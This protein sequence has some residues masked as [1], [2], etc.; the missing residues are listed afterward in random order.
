M[1]SSVSLTF[2]G[3]A[4]TVT[5][6]R[7]VLKSNASTVM[8]D[9][10]LFQ[11]LKEL[12]LKNWDPFPIKPRSIDAIVLTHA[13]LDHCGY[14]PALVRDGFAGKIFAT[15]W[16][17]KLAEVILRDSARLQLEDAEYATKKGY[18]KHSNPRPIYTDADVEETLKLF[19]VVDYRTPI[20]VTPD[21]TAIFYPS[22]H[23]LGSAF[24]ELQMSGK[25]VVFTGD[26]GRPSHPLLREPDRIP[27]GQ[28]DAIIT[29]S[30]YGDRS[31]EIASSV[32]ED[33]INRTIKRGGS[34]LI[35]AFAVDRTEVILMELRRLMDAQLIPRVPI[36]ADSPMAL[37]TLDY[38]RQAIM[39]ESLEIKTE[40]A[41]GYAEHDPFDPG[42]LQEVHSV[43]ESILLNKPKTPSIIISASGMATGG[44]VVHHLKGMLPDPKNTVLLV[45]FQAAGTRGR[46][47]ADGAESIKMYGKYVPVRA[48]VVQVGS[49]SVH[50][51]TDEMLGW[52]ERADPAPQAIYVV[53]GEQEAADAFAHRIKKD[54]EWLAVVPHDGEQVLL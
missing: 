24:V 45:G 32:F 40:I 30:T 21:C 26:M 16:T 1:N 42:T 50:A 29:E 19:Y 46:Y 12:R 4:G 25:R 39:S 37:T 34:V 27:D 18:S 52:L 47:L 51:D 6:S 22:G 33:A 13:H 43:E 44:R 23:V 5:G 8:V 36:F 20:E 28:L 17:I 41:Q 15:E 53:H 11:G 31:H 3:A 7:F 35:P 10:G 48:E 49:F 14:L 9:A 38:Y 54:L 2:L